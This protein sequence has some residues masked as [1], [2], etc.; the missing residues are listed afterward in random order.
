MKLT[1]EHVGKRFVTVG[2]EIA[3]CFKGVNGLFNF[4][5]AEGGA[6]FTLK[7]NGQPEYDGEPSDALS[8]CLDERIEELEAF[9]KKNEKAMNSAALLSA[10]GKLSDVDNILF[11]AIQAS[12]R[13]LE[14]EL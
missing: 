4:L 3:F 8:H 9:V 10:E 5:T 12:R 6:I 2:G 1:Q 11:D 14:A 13:M 7:S